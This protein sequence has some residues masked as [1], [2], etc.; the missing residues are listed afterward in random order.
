MDT[1]AA[2]IVMLLELVLALGFVIP[3]LVPVTAAAM[4]LH[5]ITFEMSVQ[6][7]GATLMQ[8][9]RP[10]IRY[11]WFS[12]ML[13]AGFVVW[14]FAEC[15]WAGRLVVFVGVPVLGVLGTFGPEL[16]TYAAR[17]RS[18][19]IASPRLHE[20]LL[21]GNDEESCE[22]SQEE[23]VHH[24]NQPSC[25]ARARTECFDFDIEHVQEVELKL[26]DTERATV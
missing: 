9:A 26:Q 12:L 19:R 23:V 22:E 13:G 14:M 20:S 17:I 10:P 24:G 1:E 11:L 7:Q 6:H 21:D 25:S 5:A 18:R 16:L 2:G 8:E 4:I 3:V 15:E